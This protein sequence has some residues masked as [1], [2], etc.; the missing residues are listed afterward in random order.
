MRAQR[1]AMM[2][3]LK[4]RSA[5]KS[6]KCRVLCA[7]QYESAAAQQMRRC[8]YVY[9]AERQWRAMRVR[10]HMM[11]VPFSAAALRVR[12]GARGV[13]RGSALPPPSITAFAA[14]SFFFFFFFFFFFQRAARR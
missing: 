11:S 2:L 4:A 9:A 14:F 8:I 7:A 6:S 12:R 10:A 13:A 3:P 1:E 5:R